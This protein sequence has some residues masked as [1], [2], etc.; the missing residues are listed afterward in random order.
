MLVMLQNL[1]IW[2]MIRNRLRL[3]WGMFWEWFVYLLFWKYLYFIMFKDL[4]WLEECLQI[5]VNLKMVMVN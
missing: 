2:D 5:W 1:L 3:N 4:Y